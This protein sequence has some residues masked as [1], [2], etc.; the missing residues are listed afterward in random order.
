VITVVRTDS[1]N[2]D[3]IQLVG[4]LDAD[5]AE[6]DGSDHSFYAQFNTIDTIRH[7]V[8]AYEDGRPAG[9]GAIKKYSTDTMEIKRMYTRPAQRGKGI[10]TRVLH[11][12]ESWA[13]EL[14]CGTCILETGRRQPEAIALYIKNGYTLIPNY[15]QYAQIDNSVCFEKKVK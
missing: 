7:V 8:V 9:C 2:H 12:L 10:A 6:R 5:L 13:A 1:E 4:H 3:F 15:G 14:S 11:E